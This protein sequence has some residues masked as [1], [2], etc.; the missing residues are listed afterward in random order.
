MEKST[1]P[2]SSLSV[3]PPA[4]RDHPSKLFVESTTRCNLSCAMCVKQRQGGES[5]EGDLDPALFAALEPV[6]PHLEALILN[7]VGEPLLHPQLEQFV[8]RGKELLPRNGWVGFQTNGLLMTNPRALSLVAAGVD[9]IC[10]SM[11][12]VSPEKFRELRRG[13][14]LVGVDQAFSTLA[15]AKSICHRPDLQV[16]VEFV[17]MGHNLH[18]LPGALRWAA[19]RGATFAIVT[20]LLPYD[21]EHAG[22]A[23]FGDCSAEAVEL[24]RKWQQIGEKQGV[25]ISRYFEARFLRYA[26]TPEEE[27]IVGLVAGLKQDADHRGIL[28]DVKK[29]I[30]LDYHRLERV[31][32][33]FAQAREVATESGL[34]L[35]LPEVSLQEKRRCGFVE[36]GSAFVSWQGDVSPCYFLWRRFDCYASG[37]SQ[38]VQPKRFGN[39]ARTPLLNIWNS[40]EFR[41]FR[42]TVLE[43]DYPACSGCTLAPCDYVQNETFEQDCHIR[44][45]PCGACL[46]CAGVFQ[47]LR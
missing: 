22:E 35:R 31:E 30:R 27:A 6:I 34:E 45:V 18:E 36:E 29:L 1:Q 43:Y 42:H 24:F 41:E 21:Q 38:Q 25:E 3:T 23:L 28:L 44:T 15:A 9:R 16:G 39:L 2:A 32:A 20:H 19:H 46:W 10:L 4:L 5:A 33:L 47:C 17:A 13:G 12:S 26:R 14:E 40:P 37:W 11:D 7:G 8:R